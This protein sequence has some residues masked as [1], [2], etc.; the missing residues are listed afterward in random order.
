[1]KREKLYTQKLP[2]LQYGP[3]AYSAYKILSDYWSISQGQN[4][5]IAWPTINRF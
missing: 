3:G 1:M 5:Q 4:L 2:L